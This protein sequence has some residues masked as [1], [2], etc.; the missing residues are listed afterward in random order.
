MPFE[1]GVKIHLR[2]PVRELVHDV[3][4]NGNPTRVTGI[5][6][7]KS[8][9]DRADA[10]DQDDAKEDAPED[11]ANTKVVEFDTVI[12]ALDLPGIK[13]VLPKNFRQMDFFD[14]I[15]NLETVP[16]ATVMVK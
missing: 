5:K 13:A 14:K 3:D 1:R 8:V 11:T 7:R 9:A 6:I 12:C 16:I 4:A 2:T 10:T 15:Y